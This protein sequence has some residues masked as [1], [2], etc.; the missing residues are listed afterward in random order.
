MELSHEFQALGMF[1]GGF[2]H[3]EWGSCFHDSDARPGLDLPP[4]LV[5]GA[6]V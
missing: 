6:Q 1:I 5:P 3:L 2:G 4:Y